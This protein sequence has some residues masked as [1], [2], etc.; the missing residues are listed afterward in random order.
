MDDLGQCKKPICGIQI[1][2]RSDTL[3]LN[4]LEQCLNIT[5]YFVKCRRRSFVG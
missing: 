2:V 4:D 5:R 3:S 1:R